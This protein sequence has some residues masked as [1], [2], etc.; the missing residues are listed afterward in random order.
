MSLF[1]RFSELTLLEKAR[2]LTGKNNWWFEGIPRLGIRDFFVADG[3]HGLRAYADPTEHHGHPKRRAPATAFPCAAAM[4]ATFQPELIYQV[5]KTIGDECNH[6]QVDVILGPGV[7]GK[8]SPLGG[9]NFEYYSEDPYLTA[10]MG[11]AFVKGAQSTGIGT[12]VKH[13][14]LN[15]QETARRFI[16]S[17]V[18]ERTF[19]ELYSYPFEQ[20]VKHAN[21]LTIMGAYN[22]VNGTYACENHEI[23]TKLL[24]NEWGY[25]GIVISDWGG[26][27]H[28]LQSL[29]A[30]L[31]I[32]MPSS[33]WKEEFEQMVLNHE[34]PESLVDETV[35]RILSVYDQL[36]KNPNYGKKTDFE[37]NHHFANEVAKEAIVLLKNEANILPLKP[38]SNLVIVGPAVFEPRAY[39]GGSSELMAYRIDTP[40]EAFDKMGEYFFI[41]HYQ[42]I[43]EHL[44]QITKA[45]AV[46]VFTGTTPAI[47][48]EGFDRRNLE[49][50]QEQID[51]VNVLVKANPNVIVVNFSGSAVNFNPFIQQ[52]KGLFQA[53]FLGSASGYA[54]ADLIFGMRNP[55]GHLSETFPLAIEHTPTYPSFPVMG[56]TTTYFEGLF[57][58]YRYYDTHQYPVLFPFGY[59]LSYSTFSITDVSLKQKTFTQNETIMVDVTVKNDDVM[60]G[61]VVVQGYI[62][63][64]DSAYEQPKKILR[65]F[66]K[67]WLKKN[68]SKCITLSISVEDVKTY[69]PKLKRFALEQGRMRLHIGQNVQ[70]IEWVEDLWME[71]NEDTLPSLK[72]DFPAGVVS[73][74][75][76]IQSKLEEFFPNMRPIRSWEAEE[77]FD[78]IVYRRGIEHQMDRASCQIFLDSLFGKTE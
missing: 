77:P 16:S 60:D 76:E 8:R 49:L 54:L 41:Q 75:K 48:S 36:L 9:R 1:E 47:E 72:R 46:I 42:A 58:G 5:G 35:K 30:G 10:Q 45:D 34:V 56:E 55:S 51:A 19:R 59:G 22:K 28:K 21:P 63:K 40:K 39:G 3:P 43:D 31:D 25:Q 50:P 4:A 37:A 69:I 20:I 26:V 61:Q 18:D 6:Y 33:E 15:E 53:W 67:V 11:I 12:S 74:N 65:T 68:E 73:Q 14:V 23:L 66:A 71:S 32:E 70:A 78:R 17:N 44:E 13:Y 29:E 64:C 27:Q 38:S 57:S 52:I 2:L 24:R 7:D 62:E